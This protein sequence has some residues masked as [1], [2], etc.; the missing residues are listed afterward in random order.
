MIFS[1]DESGK[2]TVD[3][4]DKGILWAEE[5]ILHSPNIRI[6]GNLLIVWVSN[7]CAE[8][9][10]AGRS[11]GVIYAELLSGVIL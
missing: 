2:I 6:S 4:W 3:T 8:Y 7:G 10:I 11:F 9:R 5:L 1:R